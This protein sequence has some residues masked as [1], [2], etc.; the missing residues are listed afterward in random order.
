[1]NQNI[2]VIIADDHVLVRDALKLWLRR[3]EG[4]EVIAEAENGEEL[5]EKVLELNPDVVLTDLL[6]PGKSGIEAI[7]ELY[8]KSFGRAIALSTFENEQLILDALNAGA[9]GYIIKNA[10][11]ADIIEA[12]R[13]VYEYKD[14]QCKTTSKRLAGLIE[15]LRL[16]PGSK[17]RRELFTE[18]EKAIIRLIC[19]EKS[20]EEISKILFIAPRTLEGIRSRIKR[21]M[22]V[23]SVAGFI[24]YAIKHGIY[25]IPPKPDDEYP[26]FSN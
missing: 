10:N 14:Y 3:A 13:D 17:K 20:T 6:M 7:R 25:I 26:Q 11:P 15:E 24:T 4:I 18:D 5:V 16:N 22:N 23:K 12:I 9:K 19:L 8:E 21:K 2:T 1:M